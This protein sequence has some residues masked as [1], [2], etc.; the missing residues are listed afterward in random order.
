MAMFGKYFV[1]YDCIEFDIDLYVSSG[2]KFNSKF[3]E[4]IF[5]FIN[6]MF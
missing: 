3:Y 1:Q 6:S 2:Y 4:A 5:L